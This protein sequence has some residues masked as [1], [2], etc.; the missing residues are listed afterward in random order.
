MITMNLNGSD[1]RLSGWM[2]HQ[3]KFQKLMETDSFSLP[4]VLAVNATVP[5]AV[6]ADL[7][8]AGIIEDWNVGDNFLHMEW[9]EHSEW[10]YEKFFTLDDADAQR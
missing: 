4:Q 7:L 1:W 2:R 5:G 8:R 9:V 3:W 10:V 6:Q